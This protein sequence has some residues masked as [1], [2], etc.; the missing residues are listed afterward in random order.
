MWCELTEDRDQEL[1]IDFPVPEEDLDKL[2]C[3]DQWQYDPPNRDKVDAKEV[4]FAGDLT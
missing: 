2:A 1:D 3:R 4:W